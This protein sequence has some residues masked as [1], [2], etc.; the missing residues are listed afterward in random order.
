[1]TSKSVHRLGDPVRGVLQGPG[2]P[3]GP[4]LQIDP[5][6]GVLDLP[7]VQPAVPHQME[8]GD[9]RRQVV[10]QVPGVQVGDLDL[11]GAELLDPV[12]YGFDIALVV[13]VVG[14]VLE[15]LGLPGLELPADALALR[16]D[17]DLAAG[18]LEGVDELVDR[19]RP[20]G[21]PLEGLPE[22][23]LRDVH[24]LVEEEA[25][26]RLLELDLHGRLAPHARGLRL[27]PQDLPGHEGQLPGDDHVEPVAGDLGLV[28]PGELGQ[29]DLPGVDP[30]L[31]HQAE[32]RAYR[33]V[34]RILEPL[35][36][37]GPGE[38]VHVS[39]DPP[40]RLVVVG[41]R[42]VEQ[43]MLL[44]I[45]HPRVPIHHIP[46]CLLPAASSS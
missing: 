5:A 32:H 7:G 28:H 29:V 21:A 31:Q 18:V 38:D 22:A 27:H 30:V 8:D 11:S 13:L 20:L 41:E 40:E 37:L 15:P 34:H 14:L 46:S 26:I 9:E 45:L 25:V 33:F 16:L 17:L 24:R 3:F 12:P 39:P 4:D 6:V 19:D 35:P 2:H 42:L 36:G 10:L 44:Q 1:M 23:H 43:Q